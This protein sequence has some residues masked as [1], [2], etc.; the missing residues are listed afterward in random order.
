MKLDYASLQSKVAIVVL[1]LQH[2][3]KE[4]PQSSTVN[5]ISNDC[6]DDKFMKNTLNVK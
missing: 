1:S 2:L 3:L 4:S 6:M 5:Y